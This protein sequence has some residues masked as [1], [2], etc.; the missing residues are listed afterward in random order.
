[1]RR[2]L[3]GGSGASCVGA[4]ELMTVGGERGFT[5][6]VRDG[7]TEGKVRNRGLM[8]TG[9]CSAGAGVLETVGRERGL[10]VGVRDGGEGVKGGLMARGRGGE[11]GIC[12][13]NHIRAGSGVLYCLRNE[14]AAVGW[15][16]MWGDA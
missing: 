16:Q 3:V 13:V 2:Q 4:D 1:M 10:T 12:P 14:R 6:R 9:G 11:E 7:G 15:E 5:V 8:A